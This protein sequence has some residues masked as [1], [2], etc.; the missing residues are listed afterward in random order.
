MDK[1]APWGQTENV[2]GIGCALC[3]EEHLQRKSLSGILWCTECGAKYTEFSDL[4]RVK[5]AIKMKLVTEDEVREMMEQMR[6]CKKVV[7]EQ[8]EK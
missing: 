8:T 1:K 7:Y 5:N 6:N 2:I 4:R 3:E